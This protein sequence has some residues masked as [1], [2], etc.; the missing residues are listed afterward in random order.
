[1]PFLFSG[2][3]AL[4]PPTRLPSSPSAARRGGMGRGPAGGPVRSRPWGPQEEAAPGGSSR[5]IGRAA[6]RASPGQRKNPRLFAPSLPPGPPAR[7][8]P[9]PRPRERPAGIVWV[10]ARACARGGHP[11]TPPR[12]DPSAAPHPGPTVTAAG[13]RSPRGRLPRGQPGGSGG[14]GRC[15]FSSSSP[16]P[17]RQR[18]AGAAPTPRDAPAP[19]RAPPAGVPEAR[20]WE[21]GG[22][23]CPAVLLAASEPPPPLL[24]TVMV[25][26][27]SA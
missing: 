4:L 5:R 27:G 13:P 9:A 23:G 12:G 17:Q 8:R 16:P 15:C 19:P 26:S 20:R 24:Q 21:V 2:P 1:M 18:R 6:A 14:R 10:R 25:T 22:W 7:A 11:P 3:G